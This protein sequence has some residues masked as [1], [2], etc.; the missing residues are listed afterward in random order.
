[1]EDLSAVCLGC[2]MNLSH[3]TASLKTRLEQL[4]VQ[5][6]L[7]LRAALDGIS[8]VHL[9]FLFCSCTLSVLDGSVLS[10]RIVSAGGRCPCPI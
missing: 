9:F 2:A 7:T 6:D 4:N 1:M 8:E 5:P 3:H 10:F